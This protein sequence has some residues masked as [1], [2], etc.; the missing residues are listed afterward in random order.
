MLFPFR[1]ALQIAIM[2]LVFVAAGTRDRMAAIA[3][4]ALPK[5][6]NI[7]FVFTDDQRWDTIAALGNPEIHTPHT[8]GLVKRGFHFNNAYCMGSMVGAVCLPSRTML[9]TGRSLWHIP[10]NP[11]AK[12]APPNVPTVAGAI[13]RRRLCHV[14]LRQGRQLLHVRQRAVPDEYRHEW[15]HA[16]FRHRARRRSVEVPALA[17]RQAAVLHLPGAARAARSSHGAAAVHGDVRSGKAH[18]VG[19]LHARASVRQWRAEDSRR[20]VGP[21]SAHARTSCGSTWPT[22]TPRFRTS[23]TK[24]AACSR[25]STSEDLPITRSSSSPAIKGSPSVAVTA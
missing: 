3:A 15:P 24:L 23:T 13:E 10:D 8:D 20:D 11:R 4:D 25:N 22:T 1:S 2:A 21:V 18:A 16:D 9:I 12:K 19:Q 7:L 17:R 5:R 6:P 14:P